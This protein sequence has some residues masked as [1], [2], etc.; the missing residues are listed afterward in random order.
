MLSLVIPVYNEEQLIDELVSR[1]I[2]SV[3]S[4]VDDY[5]LLFVDDGST[6][7]TVKMLLHHRHKNKKIKLE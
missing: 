4:F 5:E 3:E 6:D 7:T 2:K 1:V